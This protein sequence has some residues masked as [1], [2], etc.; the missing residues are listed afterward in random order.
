MIEHRR[1]MSQT[2]I[3]TE[4]M[5][6]ARA[7]V[8]RIL[9]CQVPAYFFAGERAGLVRLLSHLPTW[10]TDRI[11]TKRSGLLQWNPIENEQEAE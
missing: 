6:F 4:T 8:Q 9:Q 1:R 10:I 2:S 11:L 7:S 3:N 5:E